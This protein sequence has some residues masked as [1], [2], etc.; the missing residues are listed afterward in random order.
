[1]HVAA[2]HFGLVTRRTLPRLLARLAEEVSWSPLAQAVDGA[3]YASHFGD[4]ERNGM[5]A[6][7]LR[8][9]AGE[10][11]LRPLARLSRR[12]DWFEQR[13]LGPRWPH[14]QY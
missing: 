5:L 1:V 3:A 6:D 10:R 9:A 4:P 11:V 7:E 12:A 2:C 14:L 8:F 13:A